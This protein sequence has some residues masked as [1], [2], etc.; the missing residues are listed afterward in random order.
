MKSTT[1]G[2]SND[3]PESVKTGLCGSVSAKRGAVGLLRHS[4]KR[5]EVERIRAEK[6]RWPVP[7]SWVVVPIG[8]LEP[9]QRLSLI[10]RIADFCF[11]NVN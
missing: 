2:I 3:V 4:M 7:G 8:A 5:R 10:G 6:A 1:Y 9:G 11:A